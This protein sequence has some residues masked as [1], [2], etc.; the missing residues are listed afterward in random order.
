MLGMWGVRVT[1][2][3]LATW[4]W[5]VDIT[6]VFAGIALD[7]VFRWLLALGYQKVKKTI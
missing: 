6:V 3:A 1:I 4:V 5:K 7:Q 2:A